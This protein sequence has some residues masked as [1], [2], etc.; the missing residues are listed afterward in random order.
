MSLYQLNIENV[1]EYIDANGDVVSTLNDVVLD[2]AT[3]QDLKR[4]R[5][6]QEDLFFI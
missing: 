5:I 6:K 3:V 4:M 2:E 1:K